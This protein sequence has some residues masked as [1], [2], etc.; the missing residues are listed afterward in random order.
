M[1]PAALLILV[2]CQLLGELI[3]NAFKLPVPGPVIGMFLLAAALGLRAKATNDIV[4]PAP[5]RPAA[6]TLIANMGLLFVPAGVGI[7]AEFG[8]VREQWLPIAAALIGST[9]LSIAVT[10]LVMQWIMG[11]TQRTKTHSSPVAGGR[12]SVS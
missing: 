3:R 1:M 4:T 10:G 6:E 5:L 8:L 12:R 2:G 7:I 11:A 9:I